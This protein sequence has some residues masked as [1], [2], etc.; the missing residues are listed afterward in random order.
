MR[1]FSLLVCITL[2][3][4]SCF[5]V[6]AYRFRKFELEDLHKFKRTAFAASSSPF[7][8]ATDTNSNPKL[9]Y[10]LDSFL[11]DT[12]TYGF[13]IIRRDSILY[14]RYF[15]TISSNT[16]LPSFSVAKSVTGTLVG[17]AHAEGK[18]KSLNDPITNYLPELKKGNSDFQKINVQHLLDM[19]SGIKSNED[20]YNP[21]SDVLKMGF[22]ANV[23]NPALK[24]DL[25]KGPGEFEYRSVNTQLL[26]LIV[27]KATGKKLQDYFAEKL[28]QQLL[29]LPFA[30]MQIEP[31]K[32]RIITG[33]CIEATE[34]TNALVIIGIP[35]GGIFH[36]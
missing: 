18:I 23:Y 11:R 31:G 26:A 27:E 14:E 4:S 6:K 35:S 12:R 15:G 16:Q 9:K 34:C 33:R 32:L 7:T 2:F 22:A 24:S 3:A 8:F 1:I 36:T 5:V 29:A 30:L 10:Y 21:F 28:W 13:L 25:E 17:I 20:Y 19:R